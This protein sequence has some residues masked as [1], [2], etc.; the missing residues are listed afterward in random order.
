MNEAVF[1]SDLHLHPEQPVILDKFRTFV[2]W[3]AINTR[4][5]YILGDFGCVE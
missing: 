2:S 3:A 5:L 4:S 1:I